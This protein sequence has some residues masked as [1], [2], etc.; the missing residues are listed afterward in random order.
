MGQLRTVAGLDANI[1]ITEVRYDH[2]RTVDHGTQVWVY[3]DVQFPS[4]KQ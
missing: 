1:Q 4:R 2:L 3:A